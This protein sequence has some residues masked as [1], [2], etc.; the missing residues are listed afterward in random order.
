MRLDITIS[1]DHKEE[2]VEVLQALA[3]SL[4][5]KN[6]QISTTT[7]EAP[8][9]D[10][11]KE[12][13]P[14]RQKQKVETRTEVEVETTVTEPSYTVAQMQKKLAGLKNTKGLEA[15]AIKEVIQ[16]FGVDK[17]SDMDA[18]DYNAL[19]EKVEAL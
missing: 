6:V 13:P 14:K 16:S 3:Q 1:T 2:A 18:K 12:T 5:G 7:T 19:L 9:G 11:K 15:A 10:A 8:E 17:L 4:G